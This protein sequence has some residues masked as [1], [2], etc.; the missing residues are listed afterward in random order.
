MYLLDILP[1]TNLPKSESQI[2]SY[3]YKEDLTQ[4]A[5][6]EID[7]NHR[8]ILG[9]VI[10]STPIKTVKTFLKNADY[11]WKKIH[12]V[13]YNK[14]FLSPFFWELLQFVSD[15]YF[16]NLSWTAKI[17][18][19]NNLKSLTKFL[20]KN[21]KPLSSNNQIPTTL[22]ACPTEAHL[23]FIVS[24]LLQTY[25]SSQI[26]IIPKKLY[27]KDFNKAWL[28]ILQGNSKFVIGLRSIPYYPFQHLE[29]IIIVDKDNPSYKS[30]DQHP[31]YNTETI[32]KWMAKKLKIPLIYNNLENTTTTNPKTNIFIYNPYINSPQK[33]QY[34]SSLLKKEILK[35]INNNEQAILFLN[36]KGWARSIVCEDCGY[37]F[38][39]SNCDVPMIYHK[40][41]NINLLT[42]HHCGQEMLAP[43]LC[44]HC[45]GGNLRMIGLGI[46]RVEDELKHL[47]KKQSQTNKTFTIKRI[48][49]EIPEDKIR[50][51]IQDFNNHKF[52]I[53]LG[54]EIILRP[55]LNPVSLTAVVSIDAMFT[56]PDFRQ[57]EKILKYLLKLKVKATNNF[58]IQTMFRDIALFQAIKNNTVTDY[59]KQNLI[60]KKHYLWPPYSQLIK[61][62]YRHYDNTKAIHES[63]Q[64][65]Q[66][67]NQFIQKHKIYKDYFII[68][69]PTPAF[70]QKIENQYQWNILIKLKIT[71]PTG[72]TYKDLK[73]RNQ[74]LQLVPNY[75]KIDV[76]PLETI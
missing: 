16:D 35:T 22:I 39:C 45:Q 20:S 56:F 48:D 58:I 28:N 26:T 72:I 12:K 6:V 42:C 9:L 62:S 74:L 57:E 8:L 5:I 71:N 70:L 46:E 47:S 3:Y 40:E 4:G 18:L 63:K 50:Q 1:L 38:K 27:Q 11:K 44:E 21:D 73:I 19:P 37:V 7:L 24:T 53:L 36:R 64:L 52:D 43:T 55:Q 29:K 60:T 76:D 51:I 67:L 75:W 14:H 69:P 33:T 59:L 30:W 17:L 61:L 41:N 68:M 49:S 2:M 10:N 32:L 23:D 25:D 54:T 13:I 65:F 34:L 66:N 15:Y 31:Y